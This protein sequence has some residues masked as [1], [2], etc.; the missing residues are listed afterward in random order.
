MPLKPIHKKIIK[1]RK[2]GKTRREIAVELS[3]SRDLVNSYLFKLLQDNKI[4]KIS[5]E[6]AIQRRRI[7]RKAVDVPL[8]KILRAKGWSFTKI[9]NYFG[10]SDQVAEMAMGV[11]IAK[12]VTPLQQQVIKLHQNNLTLKEIADNMG[13]PVGTISVVVSR[14]V[15]KGL[16]PRRK[17]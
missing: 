9:G 1:L 13:R 12:R 4:S 17:S 11:K 7:K 2:E 14:L 16:L 6:E 8:A 5:K 15:K 10:V 3:I